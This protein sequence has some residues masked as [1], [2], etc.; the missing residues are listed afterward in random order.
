MNWNS[1]PRSL[2]VPR[3]LRMTR[4]FRDATLVTLCAFAGGELLAANITYATAPLSRRIEKRVDGSRQKAWLWND[5]LRPIAELDSDNI[6]TARFVYAAGGNVPVYLAKSTNTF[7]LITDHTGTVR[8]VLKTQ[9]G[10]VVQRLD[11]DEF[12]RVILDTNPGFQPFGFAGGIYDPDTSLVR[13]SARDYDPHTGQWTSAD[14]LVFEG[15]DSNLYG[16]VRS[17]PVNY[18]DSEGLAPSAREKSV[19]FEE[20]PP[21]NITEEART[22][23]NR[24]H[25]EFTFPSG[26]ERETYRARLQEQ[27]IRDDALRAMAW[28]TEVYG[29]YTVNAPPSSTVH[30]TTFHLTP[31]SE[32]R[33]EEYIRR[34][35][36]K[37]DENRRQRQKQLAKRCRCPGCP[38]AYREESSQTK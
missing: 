25:T 24:H 29:T 6:V 8:L 3:L 36:M 23:R 30:V 13:F 16:Y 28:E 35:K 2:S 17:D 9:T 34:E 20:D 7:R 10:E 5:L 37:R 33:L 4:Y 26:R 22:F 19:W 1:R 15:Q 31:E 12:G 38:S 18:I 27:Q 11:Y 21:P 32:R 14:P